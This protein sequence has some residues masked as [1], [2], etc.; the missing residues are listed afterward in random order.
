MPKLFNTD[1]AGIINKELGPLVLDLVVTKVTKGTRTAGSLTAGTQPTSVNYSG[2]GWT[3][4]FKLGKY[5]ESL[6]QS[7]DKKV[8][9]LG[10]SI[11]V[12]PEPN[13]EI[14]IESF[15]YKIVGVE[16]DPAGATYECHGR[17]I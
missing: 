10:S 1:I 17:L 7:D 16:R 2:K 9:V 5:D 4:G 6:V 13:D 12:V 15:K 3:E 11:T 8:I 14:T